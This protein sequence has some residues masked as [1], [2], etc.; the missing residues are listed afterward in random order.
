MT[1]SQ[2]IPYL[3]IYRASI[4]SPEDD[5]TVALS[6]VRLTVRKGPFSFTHPVPIKSVGPSGSAIVLGERRVNIP[7][8]TYIIIDTMVN[9]EMEREWVALKIVEVASLVTLHF[10]HVLEEKLYEGTISTEHGILMWGEGPLTLQVGPA[11]TPPQL[12]E[13][14]ASDHGSIQRLSANERYRYQLASRWYRRGHEAVNLVDKFLFWWT[15]LEIYPR[16]GK[17]NIVKTIKRVLKEN[18]CPQLSEEEIEDKLRIG[19]IYGERKRIVHRGIAF[20]SVDD[21]QFQELLDRLRAI[22]TTCVRLLCGLQPGETLKEFVDQE[23]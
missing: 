23:R 22:T 14:L 11:V 18:V 13:T 6:D 9:L 19:R 20:A 16:S 15:V 21:K 2:R 12:L 4:V 3:A 5:L 1:I 8:G 17:T 7:K 10:P